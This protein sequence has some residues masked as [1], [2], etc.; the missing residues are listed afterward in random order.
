MFSAANARGD[1]SPTR[2]VA[3]VPSPPPHLA[4]ARAAQARAR[5]TVHELRIGVV[6][7][8]TDDAVVIEF[9]VPAELRS[10]FR[11][12]AGQHLTVL[13]QHDGV[14]L[15]RSYSLCSPPGSEKLRIAVKRLTG[16]VFSAFATERARPGDRLRVM[17]PTGRFIVEPRPGRIGRYVA[18]AAGSG[19]TP[20]LSMIM[21]LLDGEPASEV[22]LL[23]QNRTRATA[24]FLDQ[25]DRLRSTHPGRLDIRHFW[26][27]EAGADGRFWRLDRQHVE[28][29]V[30]ELAG[31]RPLTGVHQWLMCGPTELMDTVTD[32]LL[33]R[34]VAYDV[35]RREVFYDPS[36]TDGD[37]ASDRPSLTSAVTARLGGL[38]LSFA[39][40]SRGESV[41]TAITRIVPEVPYSC[42]DGV[43]ATCRMKVTA[44][45][46]EMDRCSG[47]DRREQAEGY[48]LACQAHPVTPTVSLD[49]DV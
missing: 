14:E 38:D 11:F 22:T 40:A 36:G 32:V 45:R 21:A 33:A 20:I 49:F 39:L 28:R 44:G 12:T 4:L 31:E 13:W 43:C 9:D 25:L 24:M 17:T 8:L 6:E 35:V 29:V 34:G 7:R 48:A 47:L 1:G 42:Q 3:P 10:A 16:G 41:L 19:I 46:V 30:D 26:S 15:R 18:V 37:P 2:A 23:Y 5:P 27:R